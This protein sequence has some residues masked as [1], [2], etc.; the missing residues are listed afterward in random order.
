MFAIIEA[1][2]R[3]L[4][5]ALQPRAS[6]V[7]EN[8]ALRQ[9]L[10]SLLRARPRPRLRPIDRAFWIL[11][12][13]TW[14][15]WAD[16]LAIV[17]PETVTAWHRRGFARFWTWKSR[18]VG[19]PPLAAEIVLLIEQMARDNPLWSRRRIAN[20]L[21]KLGHAVDKDT[22]A[23]YIPRPS[24][25]PRRP[26]S[27]TSKTFV[28]NHLGGT[29]AIDFLTVPTVTFGIAYVFFVL[30]L[31][32]RRV[33]HVNV[34]TQPH[35]AWAAQQIV[36][37]IGADIVPARLI[38]D[39]D[40]IFGTVFD[41]RVAHLG[42]AQ[43]KIAPRSPWQNG[44]AE[45]FVGTLWRELLDHLI[46]WGERHLLRAVREYVAYYNGDRP[47]MS[48]GANA[49]ITRSVEPPNRGKIVAIPKV[50][51]LHHRYSRVA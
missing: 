18:R 44:Y 3:A 28:R 21:A 27:Q 10:A 20:E 41:A 48:L 25:R 35:A 15:R 24:E 13:R 46:V 38:R 4:L 23:K 31:E 5:S 8:L 37:A 22:V 39:R 6:L 2:L 1:L 7:A 40:G 30:S 11:L 33:L 42:I 14:S 50:G 43:M 34:T 49:P 36:E 19:R 47:H 12:S 17:R 51:G 29:I 26:P 16:V 32:R 45:R 9:Q